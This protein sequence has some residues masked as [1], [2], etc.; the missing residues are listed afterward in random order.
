MSTTKQIKLS[1]HIAA[2]G[3]KVTRQQ[4][5]T[6][7]IVVVV[8]GQEVCVRMFEFE[9]AHVL[10]KWERYFQRREAWEIN[11]HL[12]EIYDQIGFPSL[13]GFFTLVNMWR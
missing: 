6:I 13:L 12:K 3:S 7:N 8:K 2:D 4:C 1:Q 11:Q 10:W 9:R 5:G